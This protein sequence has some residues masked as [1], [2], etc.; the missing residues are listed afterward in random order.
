MGERATDHRTS[1]SQFTNNQSKGTEVN[2]HDHT[3]AGIK[4]KIYHLEIGDTVEWSGERESRELPQTVVDKRLEG[5]RYV[6]V[7]EGHRGGR[8]VLDPGGDD[9][10]KIRDDKHRSFNEEITYLFVRT[11]KF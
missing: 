1:L 2:G 11:P 7:C 3:P 6:F 8:Y 9:N 5:N 10:P 4:E